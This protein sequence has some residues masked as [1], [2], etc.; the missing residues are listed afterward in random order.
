[1]VRYGRWKTRSGLSVFDAV[2]RF[3][4]GSR[5]PGAHGNRFQGVGIS[6]TVKHLANVSSIPSVPSHARPTVIVLRM[7]RINWEVSGIE[8]K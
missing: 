4:K 7:Q 2:Q 5:V 8:V 3:V 6:R 1:M